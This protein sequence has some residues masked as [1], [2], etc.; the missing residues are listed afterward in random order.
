MLTPQQAVMIGFGMTVFAV[1]SLVYGYTRGR[2]KDKEMLRVQDR[3]S[4]S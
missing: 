3:V 2:Q 1:G 4:T